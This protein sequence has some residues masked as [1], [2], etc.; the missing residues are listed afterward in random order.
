[1]KLLCNML[2]FIFGICYRIWHGREKE[3]EA[4]NNNLMEW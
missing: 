3:Y 2:N 4:H 1:M